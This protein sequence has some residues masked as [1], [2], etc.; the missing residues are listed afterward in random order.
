[1]HLVL[2]FRHYGCRR[3]ELVHGS[4]VPLKSGSRGS[5]FWMWFGQSPHL[6]ACSS[7]ACAHVRVREWVFLRVGAYVKGSAL[8]PAH[9]AS[10]RSYTW[11][12]QMSTCDSMKDLADASAFVG[13]AMRPRR[14]QRARGDAS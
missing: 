10:P 4:T 13:I 6:L 7:A 9:T 2:P 3:L 1:M 14:M 11:P 5:V 12:V 8:S